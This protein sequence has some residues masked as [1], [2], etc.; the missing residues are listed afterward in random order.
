[1][2]PRGSVVNARNASVGWPAAVGLDSP[3]GGWETLPWPRQDAVDSVMVTVTGAE[4]R[5]SRDFTL[6]RHGPRL[7][8]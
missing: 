5:F 2:F 4:G 1:M 8:A 6:R 3:R 7:W